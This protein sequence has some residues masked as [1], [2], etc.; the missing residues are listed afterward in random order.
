V[1]GFVERNPMLL[2][3]A[4]GIGI[5][6]ALAFAFFGSGDLSVM[7]FFGRGF[8]QDPLDVYG[9][10]EGRSFLIW[11]YPPAYFAWV[12]VALELADF[13]GLPYHGI[14]QLLPIAADV[15]IAV[16]VHVYLGW[17]GAGER[18]RL[19]GA[20]LV[21]LGPC[22]IAISGYHGQIDSVAILP[23]VLALMVWERRPHSTRGV[24]SGVLIGVGA[25]IKW[26]PLLV[27]LALAPS[28]R[29]AREAVRLFL[30]AVAVPVAFLLPFFIAEPD[31][32]AE[33]RSYSG[34]AGLGG[35]NLVLDPGLASEWMTGNVESQQLDGIS[36]FLTD[37]AG[38]LVGI[39]LIAL[40][41]FMLRHRPAPIEAAVLVWL[42]VYTFLPNFFL[43][44]LVWGL[45]FFIMAGYLKE[46]AILQLVLIPAI[47][48]VY[49]IPWPSD[50][51]A[52]IYVPIMIG[53]WAFFAAALVTLLSRTV[54]GFKAATY[55]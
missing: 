15:G 40:A 32:V 43:H 5:R 29:S 26:S 49:L 2:L 48:I 53:V 9:I 36:L 41:A 50:Q 8:E 51:I 30:A 12:V 31:A 4:A 16:A 11:P 23:A 46:T 24:E 35:L 20:A 3:V 6:I 33:L 44:Y 55:P 7:E 37:N 45:P 14:V 22:F 34:F 18:L 25:A 28:A 19:A 52:I 10:N 38:L 47:L 17:R 1:R 54:K 21:M 13:S 39:A 42:T 27:A